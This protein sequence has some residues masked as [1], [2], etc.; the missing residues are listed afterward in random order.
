[1]DIFTHMT[2]IY[3]HIDTNDDVVLHLDTEHNQGY[4]LAFN[5]DDGNLLIK[6]ISVDLTDVFVERD[7]TAFTEGQ[8]YTVLP[9]QGRTAGSTI[10]VMVDRK[11]AI[12]NTV[13]LKASNPRRKDFLKHLKVSMNNK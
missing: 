6:N 11:Q 8:A 12:V 5:L 9:A 7:I 2:S 13:V 10:N 1:M 4:Q 3:N